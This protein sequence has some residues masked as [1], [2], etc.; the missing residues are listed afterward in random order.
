MLNVTDLPAVVNPIQLQV[1]FTRTGQDSVTVD[2]G[3]RVEVLAGTNV[4][5]RCDAS[6]G[7]PPGTMTWL[8]NGEMIT[9]DTPFYFVQSD[10]SLFLPDVTVMEVNK[11]DF[12]CRVENTLGFDQETSWILVS[13]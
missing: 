12:T 6:L 8:K 4:T 10:G 2:V 13:G 1:D 5:I 7:N 3:Q 9:M 11:V